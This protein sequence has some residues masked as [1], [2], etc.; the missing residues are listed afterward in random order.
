MALMS[1]SAE[2]VDLDNLARRV[3]NVWATWHSSGQ[4]YSEVLP[5][6]PALVRDVEATL[7]GLRRSPERRRA[8]AIASDLYALLRTVTRRTGRSDLSFVVADRGMRAAEDADDPVRLAVARWNLG[9]TLLIAN[10]Y[11]AAI[12]LTTAA[13]ET[14]MAEIGQTPPALALAGALN[15]VAAIGEARAGRVW[16]AR[17]RV[18]DIATPLAQNSKAAANIGRTMFSPFNVAMHAMCIELEAGDST[19]AL[20]IAD[21]LDPSVCPSVERRFTFT[22]DVARAYEVR[23]EETGTLLYLLDAERLAPEDLA[24]DA[25]ANGMIGRLLRSA[26]PMN[27]AQAA[28]LADRLSIEV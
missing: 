24:K 2:P 27:R 19:E 22:L 8:S 26:R 1:V 18:N 21:Q 25:T 9:H 16:D 4:R 12:E 28:K 15:L 13:A 6:L 7:R 5:G 17:S 3:Q 11:D 10:E 20:R 14:V 23:H